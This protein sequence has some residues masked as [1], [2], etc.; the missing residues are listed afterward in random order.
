M[1]DAERRMTRWLS[2]LDEVE[3]WRLLATHEVGRLAW[4]SGGRPMIVP[5]NYRASDGRIVVR[6]S[7]HSLLAREVEDGY[8][9]FEVDETDPEQHTGWSVVVNGRAGFDYRGEAAGDP[10]PWPTGQRS[11]RIVIAP[12]T[13]TGRR[14]G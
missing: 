11:L 9:A 13:V 3:C 5:V 8:V 12:M 1:M 2:E 7:A 10:D 6:T 14:I 4:T